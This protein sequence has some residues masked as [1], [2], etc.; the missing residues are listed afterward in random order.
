MRPNKHINSG[1]RRSGN[2]GGGK[3][4]HYT[5]GLPTPDDADW[6]EAPPPAE[7]P[8]PPPP[9][10]GAAQPLVAE[11][12]VG[13]AS[14]G[15]KVVESHNPVVIDLTEPLEWEDPLDGDEFDLSAVTIDLRPTMRNRPPE[16]Y[17]ERYSS[18]VPGH[19]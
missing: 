6:S 10:P 4:R 14:V 18:K 5:T 8:P 3:G 11:K 12:Y 15:P 2:A 9:S 1:A 19:Q 13:R 16:S 17:F 7:P